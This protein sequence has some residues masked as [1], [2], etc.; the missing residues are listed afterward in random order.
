M[1]DPLR[2]LFSRRRG[3]THANKLSFKELVTAELVHL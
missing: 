3:S 1:V 2:R